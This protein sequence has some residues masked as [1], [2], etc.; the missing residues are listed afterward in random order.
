L[1]IAVFSDFHVGDK[2]EI[3]RLR[4]GDLLKKGQ[5]LTAETYAAK[6][7]ADIEDMIGY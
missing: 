1:N 5:V 2:T 6:P 4:K 3:E 7:E